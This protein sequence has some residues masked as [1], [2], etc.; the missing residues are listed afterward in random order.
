M[1]LPGGPACGAHQ[2]LPCMLPWL[3]ASRCI[4]VVTGWGKCVRLAARPHGAASEVEAL[5][6]A[7]AAAA[8]ADAADDSL[9][10][11]VGLHLRGRTTFREG[12]LDEEDPARWVYHRGLKAAALSGNWAEAESIVDEMARGGHVPGPRAYH[13]LVCAHAQAGEAA[14]ALGAIRRCW[15]AGVT[16]LP[17]TYASVVSAAV[18]AGDLATAEAVVASNRRAGVD[19]T[20]SWQH[21][22]VALLKAGEADKG[23]DVLAQVRPA[24]GAR[25]DA[26][27]VVWAEAPGGTWLASWQPHAAGQTVGARMLHKAQQNQ[28][29][30]ACNAR[31][32]AG[33]ARLPQG[34]AEDLQ[35]SE[36]VYEALIELHCR[37]ADLASAQQ[38]LAYM[39][40]RARAAPAAPGSAELR[41][42]KALALHGPADPASCPALQ[43]GPFSVGG[44]LLCACACPALRVLQAGALARQ[45]ARAGRRRREPAFPGAGP[46]LQPARRAA[47]PEPVVRSVCACRRASAARHGRACSTTS[48]S[49]MR[50]Q[51]VATLRVRPAVPGPHPPPPPVHHLHP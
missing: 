20:R 25:G 19:C 9:A 31:P 11:S 16:P 6:E 41:R 39:R 48:R 26:C 40:V 47:C 51:R 13:A 7:E 50:R 43:P 15:D 5:A 17:E 27:A 46:G 12:M 1:R 36:G 44:S 35:V 37:Q 33:P 49:S 8:A 10:R 3:A 45:P 38:V 29:P 30:P 23:F 24:G 4:A 42:P 28:H 34:E 2:M 14:G 32:G 21:L 18:A 22:V